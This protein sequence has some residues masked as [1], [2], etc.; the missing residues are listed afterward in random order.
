MFIN[1]EHKL[2]TEFC[3]LSWRDPIKRLRVYDA[4]NLTICIATDLWHP[5]IRRVL[6]RTFLRH[7]NRRDVLHLLLLFSFKKLPF[8]L[9]K[10]LKKGV[11]LS[12]SDTV[13]GLLFN[14]T[15]LP[16]ICCAFQPTVYS[17]GI[18]LFSLRLRANCLIIG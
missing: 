1:S 9:L 15:H 17:L 10:E 3:C 6:I 14:R 4:P 18:F 2:S 8:S 11:N 5:I 13:F 12:I 16:S 7:Q